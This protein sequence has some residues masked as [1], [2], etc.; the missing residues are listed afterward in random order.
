MA[1]ITLAIALAFVVAAIPRPAAAA[2]LAAVPP[3]VRVNVSGLGTAYARI[4][5][6]SGVV[7]VTNAAGAVVYSGNANTITRLGVRRPRRTSVHGGRRPAAAAGR[8]PPRR[9][10]RGCRADSRSRKRRGGASQP[11]HAAPRGEAPFTD[12]RRADPHGAVRVLAR[13]GGPA[14]APALRVTDRRP[15]EIHDERRAAFVQR[16]GVPRHA[17][18][19]EGRRGRHDRRERG[20]H[21]EL[22]R[23]GGRVRGAH[24]VD[25]G[26]ARLAGDRRAYLPRHASPSPWGLR[27]RGGYAGPGVR[28]PR[29]RGPFDGSRGRADGRHGRDLRWRPDRGALLGER[30]WYHRGQRERVRER[31]SLSSLRADTR[32]GNGRPST[33]RPS[34]AGI[35]ARAGSTSAIRSGSSSAASPARAASSRRRSSA[36][37]GAATSAK[38]PRAITSVSAAR[39][40]R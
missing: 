2:P 16:P 5:S 24:D 25:A 32:A 20:R 10:G 29:R 22:P 9:T 4:G 15:V 21:R 6:T 26:S 1:R 35:S 17:R 27:P 30:R 40:I 14:R 38:T 12:R 19:R 37:P 28:R 18:A 13:T 3:T 33:R 31:S 36:R 23:L 34:C 11:R 7:N 39:S 8:A